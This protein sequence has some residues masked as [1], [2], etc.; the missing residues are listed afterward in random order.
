MQ[1]QAKKFFTPEEY[2]AMEETG[3]FKSEY[4]QG[5]IFAMAG[6]S[7]NH[8]RIVMNL[9][10]KLTPAL[11]GS[12]CE[13]FM[14]D[15]RTRIEKQDA[16]SYP[17]IT[18][19]CGNMQ[20]YQ[21]REGTILNPFIIFEVLSKST[22]SFDRGKK[23]ENYR[24]IPSLQEYILIDQYKILIEQFAIGNEGKWVLTEYSDSEAVLQLYNIDF[25]IALAE[26]YNRV[27]FE[28]SQ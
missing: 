21:N 12:S 18:I 4:Y 22:E 23:F 9:V 8:N 14:S 19:V 27:Q 20:N 6:A 26:I 25:Q 13:A 10:T 11:D 24:A 15:L 1:K 28:Q 5:E 2:L 17:D 16:F 3:E 7:A